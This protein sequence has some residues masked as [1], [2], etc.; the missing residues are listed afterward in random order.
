MKKGVIIFSSFFVFLFS[1]I[2]SVYSTQWLPRPPGEIYIPDIAG[3]FGRLIRL[4]MTYE[5]V[6]VWSVL[7]VVI[8]MLILFYILL[9]KIHFLSG[10]E[11]H[12][13]AVIISIVLA[14]TSILVTN[15]VEWFL[16]LYA[17]L[18]VFV[19]VLFFALIAWGFWV[20]MHIG[21][22]K[23]TAE[24]RKNR[25]E[26]YKES[27]EAYAKKADAKETTLRRRRALK[28]MKRSL[29]LGRR[30]LRTLTFVK[31]KLRKLKFSK[32]DI[33]VPVGEL[34]AT[35][36]RVLHLNEYNERLAF[37]EAHRGTSSSVSSLRRRLDEISGYISETIDLVNPMHYDLDAAIVSVTKAERKMIVFERQLEDLE[38]RLSASV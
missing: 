30:E 23:L 34:R 14:L 27:A 16:Y 35:L 21:E 28:L 26:T 25:G 31:G 9:K 32:G 20:I 6:P 33:S 7:F 18:S 29:R 8:I 4:P 3:I 12:K 38:K 11:Q 10:E 36:K 37:L 15:I 13:A 22:R 19:F 2:K 24:W 17:L 5:L 1:I